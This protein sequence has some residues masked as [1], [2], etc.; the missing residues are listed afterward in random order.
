MSIFDDHSFCRTHLARVMVD[1]REHTTDEQRKAAW[2][3]K[4][5]DQ[6]AEFHGPDNYYWYG[7][8]CCKWQARAEGWQDWMRNEGFEEEATDDD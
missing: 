6:G 5:D 4:Y 7:R 3:Y 8:A 1:V 2:V